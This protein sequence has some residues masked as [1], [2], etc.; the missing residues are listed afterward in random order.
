VRKP[1]ICGVVTRCDEARIKSATAQVD[2]FELRLD[3]IG[4]TWP[5]I[6]PWLCKP[7][8]ATNRLR[9][10]GGVWSGGEQARID[11]L[12]RAVE[13]GASFIDIELSSPNVADVLKLCNSSVECIVSYHN[14]KLTPA[15]KVLRKIVEQE[16]REGAS[17]CKIVT[18]ATKFG[19]ALKVLEL[20]RVFPGVRMVNFCMGEA[21]RISR[22]LN[23][24]MGG[25]FA[26]AAIHAGA[27]SAPGQLDVNTMVELYS[28]IET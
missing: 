15:K 4:S 16:M 8:I 7:W 21:G 25:E 17:V 3:M 23:P 19:D 20:N 12:I 28:F 11:I 27:V 14:L 22:I 10:E 9:T 18:Q 24:L 13:A 2:L 5:D 6:V 26:Y 1:R